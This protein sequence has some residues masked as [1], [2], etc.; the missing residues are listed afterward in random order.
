VAA[1]ALLSPVLFLYAYAARK[2]R[3]K[4]TQPS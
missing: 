4:L 1:S 2:S 3:E